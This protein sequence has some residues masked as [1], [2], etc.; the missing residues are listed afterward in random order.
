MDILPIAH[1]LNGL[2]MI[3]L[4]VGLGIYLTRRWKLGWRLWFI[5]AGTFILS[6]VGHIPFNLVMNLLLNRTALVDLSPTGQLIFNAVFLGLSAGLFEELFR[7]GMFRWWARDARSWRTGI[8]IG[9]G[10]GGIEA[11]LLGLLALLALLQ[12]AAYR[13]VDLAA[14]VPADQLALAREQ[15]AAY[16]SMAWYDSLLGAAERLFTLP[17]H[18]ACAVL[19]LQ[20]F[21]RRQ[22]Y[23]L[24]LAVGFHALI[25]AT[26]VLAIKEIGVYGTEAI[27][28]GFS[29]LSLFI[30]FRLRQPEP[31]P[32]SG[33]PP[34]LPLADF[35]PQP[36]AETSEKLDDTR[37]A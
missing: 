17:I 15:I 31:A 27:V 4:P 29:L 36:I 7:Y 10:H 24:W 19:V 30:I 23:W 16:W 9:A 21:T 3:V 33:P 26:A 6:Q 1:F 18:I 11:I 22:G 2:L 37:F 8:L 13:G 12:L 34:A 32:D 25:D 35:T 5:G 28:A 14:L 20:C